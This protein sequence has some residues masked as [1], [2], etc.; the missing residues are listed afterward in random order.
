MFITKGI[1]SFSYLRGH[2]KQAWMAC[3]RVLI[4]DYFYETFKI[5]LKT[6]QNLLKIWNISN[7]LKIIWKSI[8]ITESYYASHSALFNTMEMFNK[9]IPSV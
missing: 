4:Y 8:L 6:F 7:L 9:C 3:W 2:V 1:S 5:L